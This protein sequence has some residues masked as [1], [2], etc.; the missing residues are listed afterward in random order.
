[1]T[2]VYRTSFR[3][4]TIGLL[5]I[6]LLSGCSLFGASGESNVPKGTEQDTKL[7]KR[8]GMLLRGGDVGINEKGNVYVLLADNGDQIALMSLEV[9]LVRYYKRKIEVEGRFNADTKSMEVTSVKSLSQD[10]AEKLKYTNTELGVQFSYPSVWNLEAVADATGNKHIS[11]TPYQLNPDEVAKIDTI[12]IERT[13][14]KDRLTLRE[15]LKLDESYRLPE[16]S[17]KT[18]RYQPSSLGVSQLSAVKETSP[19]D[20][21]TTFYIQRDAYIYMISHETVHDADQDTYRN[22]FLDLVNSFEFVPFSDT[23]Q[24]ITPIALTPVVPEVAPPPVTP[25]PI[26]PV[27]TPTPAPNIDNSPQR[28]VA[29]YAFLKTHLNDI[30]YEASTDGDWQLVSFALAYDEGSDPET[31]THAYVVYK[32]NVELRRVLVSVRRE[33]PPVVTKVA[34]FKPGTVTDWTLA[35]GTDDGR[36]KEK[37]VVNVA[38]AET[39]TVTVKKGM[40][41]IDSKAYKITFQVPSNWFWQYASGRYEFASKPLSE[42]TPSV[43]ITKGAPGTSGQKIADINNQPAT[44]LVDSAGEFIQICVSMTDDTYCGSFSNAGDEETVKGILGSIQAK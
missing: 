14:N 32:N 16:N 3:V 1:M 35:E 41:L 10:T 26:T 4:F 2:H 12:T 11:I 44:K 24:I 43:T 13:D 42:A 22:G 19:D 9:P 8:T 31:F 29:F 27:V 21:K 28:Q 5:M 36:G 6:A 38:S 25:L 17:T 7:D 37:K 39:T 23:P 34:Y 15:W 18:A 20:V 30:T 33:L 40:Q